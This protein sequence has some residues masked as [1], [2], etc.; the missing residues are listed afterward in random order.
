MRSHPSEVRTTTLQCVQAHRMSCKS[1]IR[2]SCG[3]LDIMANKRLDLIDGLFYTSPKSLSG[4][5]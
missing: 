2:I 1:Q 5:L 3:V 4:D